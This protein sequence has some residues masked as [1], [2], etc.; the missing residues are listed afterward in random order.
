M[1]VLMPQR[2]AQLEGR[3]GGMLDSYLAGIAEDR[4]VALFCDDNCQNIEIFRSAFVLEGSNPI[5]PKAKY[6][7]E[8]QHLNEQGVGFSDLPPQLAHEFARKLMG[9]DVSDMTVVRVRSDRDRAS[10]A[11]VVIATIASAFAALVLWLLFVLHPKTVRR[12]IDAPTA[13]D[14]KQ[15]SP[16]LVMVLCI[17]TIG[18]YALYLRLK[19][20]RALR[21]LSGQAHLVP[22]L[23]VV[24]AF[25]TFGLWGVYADARNAKILDL[26]PID[27]K[28]YFSVAVGL[29]HSGHDLQLRGALVGCT[30]H[31]P[32]R[33]QLAD[34]SSTFS[35]KVSGFLSPQHLAKMKQK[36]RGSLRGNSPSN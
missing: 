26:Q 27:S 7:G 33:S 24:A 12:P 5:L 20:T 10:E 19:F 29:R 22:W 35:P 11:F 21:N 30:R 14:F 15:R 16:Y 9:L 31:Q 34:R 28:G 17:M 18:I 36:L 32:P 3:L 25:I 2:V 13:D 8:V 6:V 1:Q 23:D 4:N